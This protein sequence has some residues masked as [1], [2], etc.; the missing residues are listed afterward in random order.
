MLVIWALIKNSPRKSQ[1]LVSGKQEIVELI[2]PNYI[3]IIKRRIYEMRRYNSIKPLF[4]LIKQ[5]IR[6]IINTL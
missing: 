5:I 6:K 4:R 1:T 3:K 2:S